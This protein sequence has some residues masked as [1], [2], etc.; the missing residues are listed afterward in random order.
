[1]LHHLSSLW[2]APCLLVILGTPGC[3]PSNPS[4]GT[5]DAA[6]AKPARKPEAKTPAATTTARTPPR[7][8]AGPVIDTPFEDDFDRPAIGADWYKLGDAWSI[9]DG[10]LCGQGARNQGIWLRRRLPTNARIEF[11]A[12]SGSSDGDIKAELWGDGAS[13]ATAT[14]YTNATSYLTIFG[15]WKNSF[16]VLARID[17]HAKD[18]LEV[19]VNP[20]SSLEREKPVVADRV[21]AFRIERSDGKTISWWV[22]GHL[23]HR[24]EDPSPLVGS[25]HEHFGFNN[26][27]V[28]VCFDNVKITP[29]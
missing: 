22:D 24:L 2:K 1:M 10:K 19:R 11:E 7:P 23:I 6:A 17:E 13:G 28:P 29:L 20:S 25:G 18:R 15:G 3:V 4:E 5:P 16:H 27:E 8:K 12:S 14:S 21:Y 9:K 26:W